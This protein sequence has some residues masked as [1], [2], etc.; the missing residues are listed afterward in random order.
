VPAAHGAHEVA[1]PSA[2]DVPGGHAWQAVEVPSTKYCP[3]TQQTGVP[4]G[5]HLLWVAQAAAAGQALTPSVVVTY[6]TSGT[7]TTAPGADHECAGQPTHA[8]AMEA[9]A[10]VPAAQLMHAV[11]FEEANVPATH[12]VHAV[13]PAVETLPAGHGMGITGVS[14]SPR[15]ATMAAISSLVSSRS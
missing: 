13:A 3:A 5:V 15:N 11:A 10:Y 7:Q 8:V 4:S 2:L 1:L 9:F 12:A 6:P 14:E